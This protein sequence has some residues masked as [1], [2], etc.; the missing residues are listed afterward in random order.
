MCFSGGAEQWC[1]HLKEREK[2]NER[3]K[4]YFWFCFAGFCVGFFLETFFLIQNSFSGAQWLIN[5]PKPLILRLMKLAVETA[6]SERKNRSSSFSLCA[7][8]FHSFTLTPALGLEREFKERHRSGWASRA[9]AGRSRDKA[10]RNGFSYRVVGEWKLHRY[11]FLTSTEIP[12]EWVL[13]WFFFWLYSAVTGDRL[14]SNEHKRK[15]REFCLNIRRQKNALIFLW[16][17]PDTDPV[18]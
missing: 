6:Y 16:G 11:L 8:H 10:N 4:D 9:V 15:C 7:P 18:V 12:W 2:R 5:F 1:L 13:F 14:R 17:W 3:I